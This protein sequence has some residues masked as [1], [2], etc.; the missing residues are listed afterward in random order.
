[1]ETV[2]TNVR[3]TQQA[4]KILSDLSNH[5]K[6]PKA[7]VIEQALRD[8]E[9]RVFWQEVHD[10]YAQAESEEMKRERELWDTTVGDGIEGEEW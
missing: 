3:V 7:Q 9:E 6:K 4:S 10:A 2:A 1:M 5:L 8:L